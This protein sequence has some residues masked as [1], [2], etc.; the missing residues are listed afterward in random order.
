MVQFVN[1]RDKAHAARAAEGPLPEDDGFV[2]LTEEDLQGFNVTDVMAP[3]TA[4]DLGDAE[5]TPITKP[6]PVRTR[7]DARNTDDLP[8]PILDFQLRAQL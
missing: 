6:K 4:P 5:V 7:A 2:N 1:D 3:V 8:A